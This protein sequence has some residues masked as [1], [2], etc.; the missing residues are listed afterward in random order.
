MKGARQH[1]IRKSYRMEPVK[2]GSGRDSMGRLKFDAR[3]P[4][5]G[6]LQK[7]EAEVMSLPTG[8]RLRESLKIS[9]KREKKEAREY[10]LL[11]IEKEDYPE[12]RSTVFRP[13]SY[14]RP[15]EERLTTPGALAKFFK[16][17][18]ATTT[19]SFFRDKRCG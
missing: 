5:V 6:K 19:R 18:N 7:L 13:V 1:N 11:S 14:L 2:T 17:L 15:S 9:A 12:C 4:R 16:K 10:D 8:D 3:T